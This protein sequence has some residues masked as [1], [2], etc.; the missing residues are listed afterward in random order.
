MEFFGVA[1]RPVFGGVAQI[2]AL[3]DGIFVVK[4]W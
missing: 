1:N 4:M 3:S 2:C